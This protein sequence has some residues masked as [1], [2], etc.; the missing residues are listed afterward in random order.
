MNNF[1]P[2]LNVLD[3]TTRDR[4]KQFYRTLGNKFGSLMRF[5]S[6]EISYL[7][8][9]ARCEAESFQPTVLSLCCLWEI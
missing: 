6:F 8:V 9:K 5:V 3:P 1:T 4:T 7:P 2:V